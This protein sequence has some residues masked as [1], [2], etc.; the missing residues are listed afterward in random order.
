MCFSKYVENEHIRLA[1]GN[2]KIMVVA[3][4]EPGTSSR[5]NLP[6]TARRPLGR[7]IL[8]GGKTRSF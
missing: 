5:G 8:P 6:Q 3:G 4:M 2:G 7:D 1:G